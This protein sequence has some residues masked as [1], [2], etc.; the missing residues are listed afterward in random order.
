LA[1]RF[2]SHLGLSPQVASSAQTIAKILK[3]V[4]VLDGRSPP[5]TYN[6]YCNCYIFH[7]FI[8]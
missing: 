1:G 6:Y 2:C 8:V 3:D 5:T 4:G 7:S